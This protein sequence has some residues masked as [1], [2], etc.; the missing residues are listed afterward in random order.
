MW[1][2][3]STALIKYADCSR[4]SNVAAGVSALVGW[5]R[6]GSAGRV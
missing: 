4:F 5:A 2:F 3:L 6:G 1:V